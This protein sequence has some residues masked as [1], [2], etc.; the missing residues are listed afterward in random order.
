MSQAFLRR[1]GLVPEL[2]MRKA[3]WFEAFS[4]DFDKFRTH[5]EVALKACSHRQIEAVLALQ[6][7]VSLLDAEESMRLA[8]V[9]RLS[10]AHELAQLAADL[11]PLRVCEPSDI[12]APPLSR[13]REI[14]LGE[15]R[16]FARRPDRNLLAR[17]AL[18]EDP[19]VIERLLENP[20]TT[21]ADVVRIA[22]RRPALAPVLATVF[23]NPRW[24][25]RPAVAQAL[26]EN[27]YTPVRIALGVLLTLPEMSIREMLPGVA[28]HPAIRRSLELRAAQ[29][30][31]KS[32][33]TYLSADSL[34]EV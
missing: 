6:A 13:D 33:E 26:C 29:L 11:S 18:D 2:A 3:L 22:S 32:Q 5:F 1:Q 16:S 10:P 31:E 7:L 30:S 21:E 34:D 23:R 19:G 8:I 24:I 20:R 27:P 9:L 12:E 15:R 17:L 4:N 28:L 14:T 25:L